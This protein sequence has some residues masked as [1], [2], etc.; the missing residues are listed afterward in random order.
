MS[1]TYEAIRVEPLDG[2]IV[3]TINVP[4][5][6]EYEAC[7]AI[8]REL[9][10]AAAEHASSNVVIDLGRVE[11][12]A[13][14]GVMPFLSVNKR[15]RENGGRLVLCNFHDFVKQVFTTTR[16]LV[17]PKSPG[18]PFEW[19]ETRDEAVAMLSSGET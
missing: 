19:A 14:V 7:E 12:I 13:S 1:P 15:V 8:G 16:L 6:W 3:L 4:K 9:K 5:M 10:A 17:N 18:S 11:F 2:T